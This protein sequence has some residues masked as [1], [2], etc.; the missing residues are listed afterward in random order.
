MDCEATNFK[1]RNDGRIANDTDRQPE[2]CET[3]LC[4][5]ICILGFTESATANAALGVLSAEP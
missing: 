4:L 2:Q 3:A 1:F 5:A